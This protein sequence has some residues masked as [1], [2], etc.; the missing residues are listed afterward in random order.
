MN[1]APGAWC[2]TCTG[3]YEN[4]RQLARVME[5]RGFGLPHELKLLA[6]IKAWRKQHRASGMCK[7]SPVEE[8]VAA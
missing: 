7:R 5:D 1:P 2:I 3:Y 8:A 4:L 6:D